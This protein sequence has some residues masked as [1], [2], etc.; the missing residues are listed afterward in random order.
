MTLQKHLKERVR[1]RMQKTG[2]SY[3]TARRHVLNQRPGI[4][5]APVADPVLRWHFPGQ[6]P[7]TT[8]LR[9]LLSHAGVRNPHT[10][11]PFSEALL[12]VIAG[13]IGM[14]MFSFFYEKENHATFYIAGRH[15]WFDHLAYFQEAIERFGMK[16]MV[17]E[18]AGRKSAD[19]QLR[20]AL[21]Q[22]APCVA[23][24]DMAL[25]PHRAMPA[26]MQ[27]GGYHVVT[28]YRLE[29]DK[30]LIGDLTDEPIALSADAFAA[31]RDRIK[32]QKNRL[33]RV[34]PWTGTLDLTALVRSGLTACAKGLVEARMGGLR[35]NFRLDALKVWADRL[36]Q[37]K[38]PESWERVF[39]APANLW[40][41]LTGIY[42]YIESYGTGGGLCRTLFADGL[43]EAADALAQ[44]PWL[45]LA[46][47]YAELGAQ[48]TALA[49][50]ALPSEVS[51]FARARELLLR[52]AELLHGGG[53]TEAVA[54]VWSQLHELQA[55]AK[56]QFPL[57]DTAIVALRASLQQ[58]VRA[59]HDG[60]VAAHQALQATLS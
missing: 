43:A 36:H 20:A 14:G 47:R 53:P 34:D 33:L 40:R 49:E 57:P 29:D 4:I 48:W 45:A 19:K 44:K 55:R 15:S 23:W 31:A 50:A 8:A 54:D 1:S 3:S 12:F 56:A 2:E 26:E 9:V 22:G 35:T 30:V 6:V 32:K 59:L 7:T 17:Q 38:D 58:R 37:S 13:G 27:G 21:D 5:P 18:T 39:A 16:P 41:A 46:K 52:R 10:G 60:E 11:V 24:V 28:A 25:L 51:L 42:E